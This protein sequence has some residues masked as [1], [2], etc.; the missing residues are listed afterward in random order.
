MGFP[1][2][3]GIHGSF[4]VISVSLTKGKKEKR[5]ISD[6]LL[7]FSLHKFEIH[8]TNRI[9]LRPHALPDNLP[10]LRQWLLL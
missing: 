7:S 4:F 5:T 6:T 1:F 9:Y 10:V 2:I 3:F 8:G